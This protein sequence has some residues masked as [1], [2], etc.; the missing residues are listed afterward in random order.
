[1]VTHYF[2]TKDDL[3][4]FALDLLVDSVERR[5]RQSAAPG[6]AT[7]RALVLGMLPTTAETASANRVWVS[8]WDVVLSDRQRT[9]TYAKTYAASRSRIEAAIREAQDLGELG[10]ANPIE[11]ATLLH[12][13]VLGLTI[14]AVLDPAGFPPSRQIALA[15]AQLHS[16]IRLGQPAG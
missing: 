13:F 9:A 5:S 10:A 8:S 3:E 2:A 4:S 6:L 16:I 14:Q 7:V 1:M 15:E 12:S 11:L